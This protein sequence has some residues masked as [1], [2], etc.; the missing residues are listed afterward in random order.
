MWAPSE[1][2]WVLVGCRV[3]G[4]GSLAPYNA[5]V[6]CRVASIVVAGA[7]AALGGSLR[8]SHHGRA[9]NI[10]DFSRCAG[11]DV[12]NIIMLLTFNNSLFMI[13]VNKDL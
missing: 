3:V 6:V 4:G 10:V 2:G 8:R 5:S 7:R 11:L 1:G 9:P 12:S 13:M